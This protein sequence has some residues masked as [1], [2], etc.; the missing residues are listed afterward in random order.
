MAYPYPLL[1]TAEIHAGQGA[2]HTLEILGKAS[3]TGGAN[4]YLAVDPTTYLNEPLTLTFTP[5]DG[6]YY[7]H[8]ASGPLKDQVAYVDDGY[9][10]LGNTTPTPFALRGPDGEPLPASEVPPAYLEISL[11]PA[12]GPAIAAYP[13]RRDSPLLIGPG[14]PDPLL[15]SL[16]LLTAH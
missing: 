11:C 3:E 4:H 2:L 14:A 13:G 10:C 12:E 15:I 9:L 5:A 8:V 1:F 6:F 7:L 16:A